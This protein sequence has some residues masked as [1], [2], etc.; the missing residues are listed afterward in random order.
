LGPAADGG[1]TVSVGVT[2]TGTR[3]GHEVVQLYLAALDSPVP[4]AAKELA[5]FQ[6]VEL[7]PGERRVLTF[8]VPVRALSWWSADDGGWVDDGGDV[9]ALFGSSSRDIRQRLRLRRASHG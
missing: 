4:R 9:E 6:K 5:G 2:N 7:E 3:A 8:T 1:H